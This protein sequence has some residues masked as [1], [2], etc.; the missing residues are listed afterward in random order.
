[1]IEKQAGKLVTLLKCTIECPEF[2]AS[3]LLF[4]FS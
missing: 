1:M 4:S 2:G 3:I